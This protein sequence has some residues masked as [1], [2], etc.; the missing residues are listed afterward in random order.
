MR[1]VHRDY[2]SQDFAR[3]E[4][5]IPGSAIVS[6]EEGTSLRVYPGCFIEIDERVEKTVDIPPGY[7]IIF[8]GDLIHSGVEYSQTNHRLHCYLTVGDRLWK[9]D[10]VSSARA[11]G[12]FCYHCNEFDDESSEIVRQHRFICK[13][14]TASMANIV[15]RRAREKG[16]FQCDLCRNKILTTAAGMRYRKRTKHEKERTGDI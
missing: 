11:K 14:N 1:A 2:T 13:E 4:G 16:T 7:C 9:P 12:Y 8:R 10:V 3:C 5:A 15:K 6:L